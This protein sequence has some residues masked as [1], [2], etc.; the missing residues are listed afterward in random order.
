MEWDNIALPQQ[1]IFSGELFLFSLLHAGTSLE[2][3]VGYN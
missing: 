3:N 2:M 1:L